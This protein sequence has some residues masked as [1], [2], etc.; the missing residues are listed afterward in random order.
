MLARSAVLLG[1]PLFL[2]CG[3]GDEVGPGGGDG[4]VGTGGDSGVGGG[5]D[6]RGA[7]PLAGEH[8]LALTLSAS[9]FVETTTRAGSDP[10]WELT[11]KPS[12]SLPAFA[13]G[14]TVGVS[15]QIQGAP[16][17]MVRD[18]RNFFVNVRAAGDGSARGGAEPSQETASTGTLSPGAWLPMLRVRADGRPIAV[19]IGGIAINPNE[20][21]TLSCF[22]GRITI[23]SQ[24]PDV[25]GGGAL[26]DVTA[27][28]PLKIEHVRFSATGEPPDAPFALELP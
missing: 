9:D 4:G 2:A 21:E 1:F 7:C 15:I 8:V 5:G 13:P 14:D 6:L 22:A 18:A 19:E 11:A 20:G 27:A 26:V 24:V 28:E 16:L 3:S 17:R 10:V 12:A 25:E 23:P